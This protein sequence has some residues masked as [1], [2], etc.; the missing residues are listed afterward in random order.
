LLAAS[1]LSLFDDP[2]DPKVTTPEKMRSFPTAIKKPFLIYLRLLYPM[3]KE[4]SQCIR[5]G[6][7]QS[8]N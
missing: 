7:H 3:E 6:S 4:L 1:K 5:V 2:E 8:Q